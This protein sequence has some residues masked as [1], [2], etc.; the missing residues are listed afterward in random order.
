[1]VQ[2]G[3]DAR[4]VEEPRPETIIS[5]ELG[6]QH[7]QRDDAA[8]ADVAGLV[9]DAHAAPANDGPYPVAGEFVSGHG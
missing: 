3:R 7:L 1:V 5:R 9:D 6:R 4:L 8:E 2:R